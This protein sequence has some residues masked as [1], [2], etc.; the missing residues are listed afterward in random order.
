MWALHADVAGW[1]A[2]QKD[3]TTVRLDDAFAP[4][5]AF[6]WT[7]RGLDEAVTSTIYALEPGRETLWGGPA[8]G[9]TGIHR[10]SFTSIAEGTRVGTEESWA[11]EPVEADREGAW[12]MLEQSLLRWL[13]FLD[14]AATAAR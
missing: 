2:W 9:I 13:G 7:T 14:R 8:G 3:V 12:R 1:P 6:V 11:G 10:W 5:G 4:G